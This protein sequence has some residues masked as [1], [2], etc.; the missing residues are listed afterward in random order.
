MFPE[1][2]LQPIFDDSWRSA[3]E[4]PELFEPVRASLSAKVAPDGLN[5][6]TS[7]LGRPAQALEASKP[8]A[9]E[10]GNLTLCR[11]INALISNCYPPSDSRFTI[12]RHTHPLEK[13]FRFLDLI[14]H[15]AH[16]LFEGDK[17]R[18][19]LVS[20]SVLILD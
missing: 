8:A 9:A 10:E 3:G 13:P 12:L 14:K 18:D 15:S 2:A 11:V 16:R 7:V 5:R 1:F 6:G 17:F 19:H 4:R 20:N